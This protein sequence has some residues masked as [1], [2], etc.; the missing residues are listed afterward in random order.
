M[1]TNKTKKEIKEY[2][3]KNGYY[4][5][6]YW[7]PFN[8]ERITEVSGKIINK[9]KKEVEYFTAEYNRI[10]EGLDNRGLD[11]DAII[12]ILHITDDH[13]SDNRLVMVYYK[14]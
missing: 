13:F 8:R 5:G 2:C 10:K 7:F 3:N 1:D 4:K 6:K 14:K 12:N 9:K 11:A